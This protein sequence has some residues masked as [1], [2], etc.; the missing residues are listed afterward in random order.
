MKRGDLF[1]VHRPSSADPR[2]FRVYV[3][4]S[5]QTVID[6]TFS[7]AMCAP[8]YS[9]GHGLR[10]E[11]T[12]GIAEGLKHTSVI[13]CD[14]IVSLEKTKLTDYVGA[15]SPERLQMLNCALAIALELNMQGA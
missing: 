9:S 7:T 3:V 13:A 5:R 12:V 1:R 6:S 8:V 4:V 14:N 15:L 2:K 10:T 11:V